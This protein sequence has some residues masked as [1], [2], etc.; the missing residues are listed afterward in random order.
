MKTP[1]EIRILLENPSQFDLATMAWLR[2]YWLDRLEEVPDDVVR[3]RG[4][5]TYLDRALE[6]DRQRIRFIWDALDS[7]AGT[8]PKIWDEVKGRRRRVKSDE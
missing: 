4:E 5:I 3:K 7:V 6:L 8:E 1:T 2:R